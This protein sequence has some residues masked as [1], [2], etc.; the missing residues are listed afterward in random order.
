MLK[1]KRKSFFCRFNQ[2]ELPKSTGRAIID[3]RP[4]P[5]P[6]NHFNSN[7]EPS[8]KNYNH[9]QVA[10]NHRVDNQPH[11]VYPVYSTILFLFMHNLL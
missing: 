7:Q 2:T 4:F 5:F 11:Y 10:S 8:S 1:L 6:L 9:R 3:S